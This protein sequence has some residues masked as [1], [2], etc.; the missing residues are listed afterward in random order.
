MSLRVSDLCVRD[1]TFALEAT[2]AYKYIFA[3]KQLMRTRYDLCARGKVCV[4]GTTFARKATCAS[5]SFLIASTERWQSMVSSFKFS[6]TVDGV[7][8]RLS[9]C[10]DL[11][12][13][14]RLLQ[15]S[16]LVAPGDLSK[17]CDLP[18]FL[19]DDLELQLGRPSRKM[20][21]SVF[22]LWRFW[23]P[24]GPSLSSCLEDSDVIFLQCW[25][26]RFKPQPFPDDDY[27]LNLV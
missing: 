8:E 20:W 6:M 25:S 15:P 10:D 21:S 12:W 2:C 27:L 18:C 13:I 19:R 7:L 4:R 16:W 22:S 23:I 9:R 26:V 11:R 1:T 17:G 5:R 14:V 3:C 24:I